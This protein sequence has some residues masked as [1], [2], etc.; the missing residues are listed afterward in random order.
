M[1]ND[2]RQ[3]PILR[4]SDVEPQD[5]YVGF[6]D[7]LGWGDKVKT[8]FAA[9]LELYDNLINIFEMP[10][11]IDD[12]SFSMRIV[13]DSIMLI[14]SKVTPI[15]M[16]CNLLQHGALAYDCLLRGGIAF[17]KHIELVHKNNYY[18]LSEPLVHAA[19]LEKQIKAP[20]IAFHPSAIPQFDYEE[21]LSASPFM[22]LIL[23]F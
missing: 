13:S 1:D 22:R 21:L 9:A 15:A 3:E 20:C 8:D 10:P 23:Y 16:A 12:G 14:C 4:I 5:R 7:I 17:G 2:Q 19:M 18:V 11:E 6:V